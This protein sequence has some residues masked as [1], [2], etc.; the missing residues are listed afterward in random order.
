MSKLENAGLIFRK[1]NKTDRRTADISLT[2]QGKQVVVEAAAQRN[3][4][5]VE[6][7]SCL[8]EGEKKEL[9]V[10]LGKLDEDWTKRYRT[11]GAAHVEI[12]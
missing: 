2:S 5:H 1:I 8:T 7:F 3:R 12:H 11:K 10:L 6:M 4:R 9:L